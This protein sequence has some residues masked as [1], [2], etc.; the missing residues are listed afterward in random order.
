M[1]KRDYIRKVQRRIARAEAECHATILRAFDR[2]LRVLERERTEMY[3]RMD[4][5]RRGVRRDGLECVVREVPPMVP[6][7]HDD[8]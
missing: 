6:K 3:V 8:A 1:R 7:G 5:W 2:C 4:R